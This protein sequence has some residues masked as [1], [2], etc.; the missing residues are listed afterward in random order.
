MK[1]RSDFVT[2]SSSSSFVAITV[3]GSNDLYLHCLLD[4]YEVHNQPDLL[5]TKTAQQIGQALCEALNGGIEE[6]N[7]PEELEEMIQQLEELPSL[8]EVETITVE[9]TDIN[10][11]EF[12]EVY[13]D[14]F[15]A[16]EDPDD[17]DYLEITS[18][19]ETNRK[20]HFSRSWRNINVNLTDEAQEQFDSE[21]E[22]ALYV[23]WKN[24]PKE[25]TV[26]AEV[27]SLK[28]RDF[29]ECNELEKIVFAGEVE[30]IAADA[31]DDLPNLTTI[32][33]PQM[34]LDKFPDKSK[35]AAVLG[36]AQQ[37]VQGEKGEPYR[38]RAD[39]L[40]YIKNRQGEL[41]S[42]ILEHLALLQVMLGENIISAKKLP[43]WL[44]L[45]GKAGKAK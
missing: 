8:D 7:M 12:V 42:V 1:I 39:Y 28:Y 44:N 24:S 11:G 43:D 38:Y 18:G 25:I 16:I 45:G 32:V 34:L 35:L 36:F 41:M 15:D 20:L 33:A 9:N 23:S 10:R 40:E 27:Q 22:E 3:E 13:L 29:Y 31:F 26:S 17:V 5:E 37:A 30:Q 2:N 21:D 19:Y 6:E 4:E 14:D